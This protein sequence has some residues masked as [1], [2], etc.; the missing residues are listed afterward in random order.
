MHDTDIRAQLDQERRIIQNATEGPWEWGEE[1]PG[2]GDCGP[3]LETVERGPVYF[4]GS[5]GA[6]EIVIGSWGHDANGIAVDPADAEFIAH[7]RTALPVRNAQIE[8]VLA[9]HVLADFGECN[10]CSNGTPW[11]CPTVTAIE[12]AG[13]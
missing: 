12:E 4:D 3:N 1:S 13:K 9:L 2:W 11:P 6:K 10:E 7:A 5:Q 8:A